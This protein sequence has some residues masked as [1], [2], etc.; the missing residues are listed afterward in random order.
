MS[1]LEVRKIALSVARDYEDVKKRKKSKP[2]IQF[3]KQ[4]CILS[5]RVMIAAAAFCMGCEFALQWT[6]RGSMRE[7]TFS[8]TALLP[9]SDLVLPGYAVLFDGQWYSVTRT[10]GSMQNSFPAHQKTLISVECEHYSNIL[11]DSMYDLPGFAF[12]G[13]PA[14]GL[15]ML[16]NVAIR[17]AGFA[18]SQRRCPEGF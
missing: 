11:N 17:K 13:N 6:G 1:E 4:M 18:L 15:A 16:L 14:T 12:Q 2:K 3:S 5:L 8:F 9:G 7:S 10:S